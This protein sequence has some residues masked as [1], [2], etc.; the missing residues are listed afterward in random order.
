[1]RAIELE[2]LT[3]QRGALLALP[4]S[5][6]D[7]GLP[8]PQAGPFLPV[9]TRREKATMAFSDFR[10]TNLAHIDLSEA[11]LRG[12]AF[13]DVSLVGANFSD[14][15]PRGVTFRI[16]DLRHAQFG[17]SRW[18][19]NVFTGSLFTH[20]SG[21]IAE[22]V[23]EILTLGGRFADTKMRPRW[24]WENDHRKRIKRELGL[25]P[26]RVCANEH[27][28]AARSFVRIA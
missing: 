3:A 25:C 13:E 15:D 11:D 23:M 28:R 10:R 9:L 14:A 22:Q 12:A 16:C 6:K 26:Q 7:R 19:A 8:M 24:K 5:R 1:M 21:L 17:G 18:G 20:S 2:D 4:G 27:A